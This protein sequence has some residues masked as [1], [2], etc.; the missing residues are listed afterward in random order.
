MLAAVI[1]LDI[2]WNMKFIW[3]FKFQKSGESRIFSAIFIE[4]E[5]PNVSQPFHHG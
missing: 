2:S 3:M 5:D 4:L 1:L